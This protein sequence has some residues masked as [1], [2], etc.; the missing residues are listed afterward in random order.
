MKRSAK[1][2]LSKKKTY[3]AASRGT[4][5]GG[6]AVLA[7]RILAAADDIV[8]FDLDRELK[9]GIG[10][11]CV[12]EDGQPGI[13]ITVTDTEVEWGEVTPWVAC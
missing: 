3:S 10:C 6:T 13:T 8:S 12:L 9:L 2:S 7:I 5:A 1:G 4:A 11:W